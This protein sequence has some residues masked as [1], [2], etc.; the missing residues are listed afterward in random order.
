MQD[1]AHYR[2]QAQGC[3]RQCR[4]ASPERQARLLQWAQIFNRFADEVEAMQSIA[5]RLPRRAHRAG[6]PAL[7]NRPSEAAP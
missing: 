6:A 4:N 3:L 1:A 7:A 5:G 2:Q